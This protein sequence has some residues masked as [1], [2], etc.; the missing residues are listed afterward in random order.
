[1]EASSTLTP[2]SFPDELFQDRHAGPSDV[3]NDLSLAAVRGRAADDA[4]RMYLKEQLTRHC[5]RIDA[6]AA[7]VGI[8][9]RQLHKLMTKHGLKKER[10]RKAPS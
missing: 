7:A 8:S 1:L 10:F 9:T 6:T 4:E 5:G 2:A 3:D